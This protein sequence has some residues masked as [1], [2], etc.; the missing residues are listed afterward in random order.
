[1]SAAAERRN[2]LDLLASNGIRGV[3]HKASE[4]AR[5]G[6]P[7]NRLRRQQIKQAVILYGSCHFDAGEVVIA[8]VDRFFKEAEPDETTWCSTSSG[9]A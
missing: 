3:I 2:R 8:Q 1:M 6:D 7:T 5:Y 4:G 9:R